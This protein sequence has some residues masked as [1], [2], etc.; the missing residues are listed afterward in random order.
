MPADREDTRRS[1]QG[2]DNSSF[3][4]TY[5]VYEYLPYETDG[6]SIRA[7]TSSIVAQKITQPDANTTYIAIAPVGTAQSF[8][9]WQVKKILVNGNDTTITWADSNSAFDNVATDL[10]TLTY[11]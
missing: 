11:G 9:G 10:T 7:K 3:N 8:A 6:F 4:D 2:L 1:T 5:G